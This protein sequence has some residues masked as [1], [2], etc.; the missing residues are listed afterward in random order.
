MTRPLIGSCCHDMQVTPSQPNAIPYAIP[1][2]SRS[3][4][5]N[6]E[7]TAALQLLICNPTC[8]WHCP[9]PTPA[10][11]PNTFVLVHYSRSPNDS[12]CTHKDIHIRLHTVF[13]IS[14]THK[15]RMVLGLSSIEFQASAKL[16]QPWR[17]LKREG[18]HLG[19]SWL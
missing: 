13:Q 14:R 4:K 18:R 3:L 15:K 19:A 1:T 5:T 11:K 9:I 12:K 2:Q 8:S 6:I 10:H 16:W 7:S 17:S